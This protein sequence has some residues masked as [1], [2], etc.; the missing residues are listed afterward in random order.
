MA[1]DRGSSG[2]PAW[3]RLAQWAPSCLV[4]ASPRGSQLERM[5]LGTALRPGSVSLLPGDGDRGSKLWP[6]T[7]TDRKMGRAG[8][9]AL[10]GDPASSPG[11]LLWAGFTFLHNASCCLTSRAQGSWR[12][13]GAERRAR[14]DPAPRHSLAWVVESRAPCSLAQVIWGHRSR[15]MSYWKVEP[16]GLESQMICQGS[17]GEGSSQATFCQAWTVR[18]LEQL[19]QTWTWFSVALFKVKILCLKAFWPCCNHE[20]FV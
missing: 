3:E 14:G 7:F 20:L 2:V 1:R 9:P 11:L 19:A 15:A 4:H 8:V 17:Q 13:W 5:S 18:C 6:E 10:P 12:G 16:V